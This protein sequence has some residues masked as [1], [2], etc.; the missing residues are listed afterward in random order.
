MTVTDCTP[1]SI[2]IYSD[3][4]T[5]YEEPEPVPIE[6]IGLVGCESNEVI[7]NFSGVLQQKRNLITISDV[8]QRQHP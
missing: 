7:L 2:L 3:W 6:P 5:I 1:D 8:N 4:E